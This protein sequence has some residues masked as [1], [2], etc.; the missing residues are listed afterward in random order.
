MNLPKMTAIVTPFL[1]GFLALVGCQFVLDAEEER[2]STQRLKIGDCI[3]STIPERVEIEN[4]VLV[5]CDG[6][7]QYRV[8]DSFPIWSDN[9]PS[10]SEFRRLGFTECDQRFSYI[11]HPGEEAWSAKDSSDKSIECLQESFGLSLTDRGKLDRMVSD[12][13]LQAGECFNDVPETE[14]RQVEL[15][16]CLGNWEYQVVEVISIPSDI[17]Y[18]NDSYF[19][20]RADLDCDARTD[21]FIFPSLYTWEGGNRNIICLTRP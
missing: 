17:P 7:W 9:Y 20:A 13:S 21:N 14:Y 8:V 6:K 4:V 3:K 15:V 19:K 16:T 12:S 11:M 18:P 2:I 1:M 5:P 10:L